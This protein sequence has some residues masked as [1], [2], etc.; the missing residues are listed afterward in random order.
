MDNLWKRHVTV[1][2]W[3]C[4]CKKSGESVNHLLLYCEFACVIWNTFFSN[5]GLAWGYAFKGVKPLCLLESA[6]G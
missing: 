1:V 4:M 5:V 2:E 3:C 6:R